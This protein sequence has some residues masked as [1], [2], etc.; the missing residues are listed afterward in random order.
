[1]P[2][3]CGLAG[4]LATFMAGDKRAPEFPPYRHDDLTR[5]SSR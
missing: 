4:E 1:M 2:N 5:P 3:A